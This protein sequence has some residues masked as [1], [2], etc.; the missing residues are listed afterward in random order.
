MDSTCAAPHH[1]GRPFLIAAKLVSGYILVPLTTRDNH[2]DCQPFVPASK[3]GLH[4]DSYVMVT[5]FLATNDTQIHKAIGSIDHDVVDI[6]RRDI[7]K[8]IEASLGKVG[9]PA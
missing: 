7:K 9:V 1:R 4:R 5:S 2:A 3:G 8:H 6:V